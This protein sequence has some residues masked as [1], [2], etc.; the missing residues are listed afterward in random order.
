MIPFS[1]IVACDTKV[2][3]LCKMIDS[4]TESDPVLVSSFIWKAARTCDSVCTST[5]GGFWIGKRGSYSPE[6]LQLLTNCALGSVDHM[7]V[8]ALYIP[9]S[10][11]RDIESLSLDASGNKYYMDEIAQKLGARDASHILVSRWVLRW[12]F[13]NFALFFFFLF[14]TCF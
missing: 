11:E 4:K 5:G 14:I 13:A 6:A 9:C 10:I 7:K 8:E 3:S 2:N 12:H 1:A